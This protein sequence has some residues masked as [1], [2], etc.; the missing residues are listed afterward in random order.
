MSKIV[1][2]N[3]EETTPKPIFNKYLVRS[4]ETE[5]YEFRYIVKAASG[6][7]AK[8]KV[9]DGDWNDIETIDDNYLE[10]LDR[11]IL[12]IEPYNEDI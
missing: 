1:F 11:E 2:S 10:T 8:Q 4:R 12:E 5:S 9:L 3:G 6:N 7:E